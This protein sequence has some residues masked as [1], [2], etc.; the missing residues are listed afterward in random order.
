MISVCVDFIEFSLEFSCGDTRPARAG[1][2]LSKFGILTFDRALEQAICID[3][4]EEQLFAPPLT[5]RRLGTSTE[6]RGMRLKSFM[7]I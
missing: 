1:R 5:Y 7:A 4:I 6:E 3:E 2:P